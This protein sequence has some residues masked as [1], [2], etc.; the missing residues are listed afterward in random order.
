[1][2]ILYV[3]DLNKGGTCYSRFKALREIEQD[4]L[5]LDSSKVLRWQEFSR[6]RRFLEKYTLLGASAK[7]A[8]KILIKRIDDDQP[9][10]VLID[11][12]YWVYEKTLKL[13]RKKKVALV[14]YTTDAFFPKNKKLHLSRWLMRK[15]I[16]CFDVQ[17]TTNLTDFSYFQEE[18]KYKGIKFI[19]SEN[20]YDSDRFSEIKD[21]DKNELR[22]RLVFIG[23]Y[24]PQT[25]KMILPIIEKGLPLTLYGNHHWRSTKAAN[26]LGKNFKNALNNED[27]EAALRQADIALCFVSQ[28]NYNSTAG[29]TFEIT[30]SGTFLLA[31]R[32]QEHEKY[33]TEGKE[34][35]FFSSKEE[36]IKKI[37]YYLAND[38]EREKIAL[39]GLERIKKAD[40]SWKD[41]VV[42]DW[43]KIKQ[44]LR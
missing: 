36:L 3:G 23:H 26:L 6:L 11:T 34:A 41:N 17:V 16:K 20:G 1:M 10:L 35:E 30:R 8:N 15:T 25:E 2:K 24:E 9:D 44:Y 4:V 38:V 18:K 32:T 14:H 37:E 40:H 42:R 22:N 33:F 12:N 7:N 31:Q 5:T 19:K 29:R 27:Y 21:N 28:W 13:I 43:E 39:G